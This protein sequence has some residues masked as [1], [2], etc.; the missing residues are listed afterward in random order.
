MGKTASPCKTAEEKKLFEQ[1]VGY[2]E[3][4]EIDEFRAC[5][6]ANSEI[7][8]KK[9][10]IKKRRRW[11]PGTLLHCAV[12][13]DDARLPFIKLILEH[14]P[15]SIDYLG[16]DD[17]SYET[18][19]PYEFLLKQIDNCRDDDLFVSLQTICAVLPD[20]ENKKLTLLRVAIEKKRESFALELLEKFKDQ[21]DVK[22]KFE[23]HKTYLHIAA[24][25]GLAQ[26]VRRLIELE[27]D[28]DAQTL[29]CRF[30][31]KTALYTAAENGHEAVVD[32]LLEKNAAV[33]IS[34][35]DWHRTPLHVAV[36]KKHESIAL[37]LIANNADLTKRYGGN[38]FYYVLHDAA[39]NGLLNVLREIHRKNPGLFEEKNYWDGTPLAC[40]VANDQY[41]AVVMLYAYE[42]NFALTFSHDFSS[43]RFAQDIRTITL[44]EF[45]LINSAEKV[46]PF[47]LKINPHNS[48]RDLLRFTAAHAAQNKK[49]N[50]IK[51]ILDD[52]NYSE[53]LNSFEICAILLGFA[54]CE[55]LVLDYLSEYDLN[56]TDEQGNTL[57]HFA[58]KHSRFKVIEKLLSFESIEIKFNAEHYLPSMLLAEI[59][60][61]QEKNRK[62]VE[63]LV[64]KE[65]SKFGQPK[66]KPNYR[67]STTLD[68]EYKSNKPEKTITVS[69]DEI[70]CALSANQKYIEDN[71]KPPIVETS[72]RKCKVKERINY[73]TAALT[74][75]I[76]NKPYKK[77]DPELER[78]TVTI[79]IKVD[80]LINTFASVS[81]QE[82]MRDIQLGRL[83]QGTATIESTMT[84]YEQTHE[85][86]AFGFWACYQ[87]SERLWRL[88]L[89]K[90]EVAERFAD[91]LVEQGIL[92]ND[93]KLYGLFMDEHSTKASCSCCVEGEFG[94]HHL[95]KLEYG[96]KYWLLKALE[97]KVGNILK[98][99]DGIR[100]L[101]RLSARYSSM[102]KNEHDSAMFNVNMTKVEAENKAE[103]E[104][105]A[106]TKTKAKTEVWNDTII[107]RANEQCCES[108]YD[109][110]QPALSDKY[111]TLL[112]SQN[113]Q[114]GFWVSGSYKP[115]PKEESSSPKTDNDKKRPADA[116]TVLEESPTK[117]RKLDDTDA[118]QV[119]E[120]TT[121]NLTK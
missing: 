49:T 33:D 18:L 93:H 11:L 42:A 2:I 14:H 71:Y 53:I 117:K 57:L 26:V 40:A 99:K 22:R 54:G 92:A 9:G 80:D 98:P 27:V 89:N 107:F 69:G 50:L 101:T 60:K 44:I 87:H 74:F 3:E 65:I 118:M 84:L 103:I 19:T 121:P 31:D 116:A 20:S 76:S 51:I 113:N 73:V 43:S 38:Y 34:S 24:E 8:S 95:D 68:V 46:L 4:N 21:I 106:E 36:E 78:V 109:T 97:K 75:M 81:E 102:Q 37:K 47:L 96:F 12:S 119:E 10:E 72:D 77:G 90:K 28:M 48:Q 23:S 5:V 70:H 45:A 32:V 115:R 35:N 58:A 120:S 110:S 67:W 7:L 66:I 64:E 39:R 16:C 59:P 61:A 86:P 108:V 85:K 52:K 88:Y 79:P 62:I 17:H 114:I 6:E 63:K 104:T 111:K 13:R 15:D 112:L 105:E 82:L 25:H 83:A 56:V 30:L 55:D 94:F 100:V 41:D 1:C 29:S 91:Q